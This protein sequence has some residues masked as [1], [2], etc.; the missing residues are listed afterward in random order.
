MHPLGHRQVNRAGGNQQ[1]GLPALDSFAAEQY[2]LPAD[3]SGP[4][5]AQ[6]FLLYE[7]AN[8]RDLFVRWCT[9]AGCT[10]HEV[11][12]ILDDGPILGQARLPILPGDSADSLAARVLV[13]DVGKPADLSPTVPALQEEIAR[14]WS[15]APE[16]PHHFL[17]PSPRIPL[18]RAITAYARDEGQA[19]NLGTTAGAFGVYDGLIY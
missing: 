5:L 17:A 18:S 3:I 12:P 6:Y 14:L 9:E 16:S 4:L 7:N 13:E 10:V 15:L 11:T 19:R 8:G 1:R 2:R